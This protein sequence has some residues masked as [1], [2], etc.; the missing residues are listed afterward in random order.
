MSEKIESQHATELFTSFIPITE[1]LRLIFF[2]RSLL[3]NTRTVQ[4]FTCQKKMESVKL[5]LSSP[6]INIAIRERKRRFLKTAFSLTENFNYVFH[7][8]KHE[9]SGLEE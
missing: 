6:K 7:Q 8:I 1:M 9:L 3:L 4:A 5:T 2:E